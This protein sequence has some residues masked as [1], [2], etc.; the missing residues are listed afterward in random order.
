LKEEILGDIERNPEKRI[1]RDKLHTQIRNYEGSRTCPSCSIAMQKTKYGKYAP[2]RID[3]CP[4]CNNIWLDAGELEDIQVAYEMFDENTN[5]KNKSEPQKPEFEC[6]KCGFA[7]EQGSDCLKCGI[8]FEKYAAIQTEK[9]QSQQADQLANTKEVRIPSGLGTFGVIGFVRDAIKD[10]P[11]IEFKP[12]GGIR[13]FGSKIGYA[14]SLGFKE[15]EIFVFGLLQWVAIALAYLLWI[16]MLDWIP[17]EVWR[18]AAE[19]E[20]ASIV[21]YILLAW[22]FFCVGLAAFPIGI[23]TGCM[24]VAHFLHKQGRS[25]SIAMCLKLVLPHSW[26]LWIFHWIDGWITVMQILKRLPQKN[27]RRTAAEKLVS[28]AVYYAWKLGI[29]GVL[30]SI[31]TGNSLIISAKNSIGFVREEFH[32]LARLRAGYSALC[33]IVGIG[34]YIGAVFFIGA[35]DLVPD[36][37]EIYS[38][39]YTIYFWI[40]V[41]MLIAVAIIMLILRPIYVLALC[42]FYSEYLIRKNKKV[43]LPKNPS[44]SASALVAFGILCICLAVV[45]FYRNELGIIDMLST[46][47]GESYIPE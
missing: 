2:K 31:V 41:P 3:K 43:R 8:Y 47:Y 20:Q 44:A 32:V 9:H 22:G 45:F 23:L 11:G 6:P 14:L 13:N 46:P 39:I 29:S 19:S 30:P 21:D 40:A 17:E 12:Q 16:Q 42:D 24:G 7:Q 36:G 15:K 10:T 4:K 33:W 26:S 27:N 28:E 18:S 5:K 38:H 25:S 37:E 34:S 35:A 1:S